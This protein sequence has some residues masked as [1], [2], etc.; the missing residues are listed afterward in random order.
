MNI[1]AHKT[2]LNAFS[3]QVSVRAVG[4]EASAYLLSDLA[5]LR[6]LP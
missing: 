1:Y 3:G 2:R 4:R 5:F 6:L